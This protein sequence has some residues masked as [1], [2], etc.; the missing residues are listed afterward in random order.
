MTIGS[1][2]PARV[3]FN[4]DGVS[5]V[6]PIPI[7]AYLAADIEVILTAPLSAGG[8][9]LPLLLNS[10]YSMASTGTLQPPAWTLTTL[11]PSAYPTGYTLQAFIGPTVEQQSQ[12]VQGQAFPSLTVQTNF[13]RLTQMVQR[14]MDAVSR[15]IH[16]PDGDNT[17]L[18][19]LPVAAARALMQVM[20]DANGN[21]ALGVPNN[22]VITTALLAPFLNQQQAPS[23]AAAN[24]VPI[25]LGYKLG[26]IRRYGAVVDGATPDAAAIRLALDSVPV[27][28]GRVF[29]DP[30]GPIMT[31]GNPIYIPQRNANSATAQGTT[32]DFTGCVFNGA[33]GQIFESGTGN[34]ST[35]A[36]G[37]ATNWGLGNELPTT[38]HNGDKIIGAT[39]TNY[40][41]AVKLFNFLAGCK[42]QDLYSESL[43][44]FV[45]V[46]RS[47]Y[48]AWNNVNADCNGQP[49]G[50][51][52][53][54]MGTEVNTMTFHDVHVAGGTAA[55]GIGYQFDSGVLGVVMGL[56]A[57]DLTTGFLFAGEILGGTITGNYFENCTTVIQLGSLTDALIVEGNYVNSCAT[58]I[59]GNNWI[60]GRL[61][62]NHFD[63]TPNAV[64]LSGTGNVVEVWVPPRQ[65]GLQ[66]GSTP[67]YGW[68]PLP[69]NWSVSNGCKLRYQDYVFNDSV[70]FNAPVALMAPDR[71]AGGE[72][73]KHYTGTINALHSNNIP[74]CNATVSGT[75]VT[76]DTKIVFDADAG[77]IEFDVI[78]A[79]NAASR[80]ISG[81]TFGGTGVFRYDA[82]SQTVTVSNQGG[83]FRFVFAGFSVAA[84]LSGGEIRII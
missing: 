72:V 82:Q 13:D 15:A 50:T 67:S 14:A 58:F 44:T 51:P 83:F 22:Q 42:L 81:R 32:L 10:D 37:G 43:G 49:A 33:G 26:N 11:A 8:A 70:G 64:N 5:K 31:D 36:K 1:S 56:G 25:N 68:T 21:L 57:E 54:R 55:T 84:S 45:Y 29:C 75:T 6:F 63:G 41:T 30:P 16:A 4:C 61:G 12:Y 24:V 40:T 35:V 17:P 20:F 62:H 73:A 78:I 28:G 38:I 47:F 18:M 48:L 74:F 27:T 52:I 71:T 60:S 19:M 9:E 80:H 7:Q 2:S 66:G 23:E 65:Y 79:D 76:V 69:A 77:G 3:V 59:N 46:D 34:R 53:I 39:F